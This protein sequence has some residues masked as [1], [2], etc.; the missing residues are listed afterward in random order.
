M[1]HNVNTQIE[2]VCGV[3]LPIG[4]TLHIWKNRITPVKAQRD[5]G[6][7][8]SIVTGI[9]GDELEGQY[10][11]Y[12]VIRRIKEHPECLTGTVDIYP[13]M[14]PL[15]IDSVTRG[16]PGFDL[17]MNRVFPG[18]E[19]GTMTEY[20]A[21]QIIQDLSGADLCVDIHASNI[22]L[23]EIP[24]IRINK[25]HKEKLLPLAEQMN[26]DFIWIHG[27]STVLEATLAYSLNSTGTPTLVVE[28]GV[29]MRITKQYC[30]Q[31]AD[32]LFH[33]MQMLGI[34]QS[35]T[36]PVRKPY[37]AETDESVIF[38]NAPRSGIFIPV[39]NH[40]Q[41]LEKGQMVGQI[42]DS[43]RGEVLAEVVTPESGILFTIREYPV[44]DEGSL[45]GRLLV[46]A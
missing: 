43:L 33:T 34:W 30:R 31:L 1:I 42:V 28:A 8:I 7:R 46:T 32:G 10:I 21:H 2:E 39:A 41:K 19:H 13:A 11:C 6:K 14:N 26:V 35:E 9:H 36:E 4:E 40:W 45:I 23:T 29:G 3:E 20:I 17:D 44:V 38:F 18:S 25:L 16:I 12:E 22:Y 37:I 24:Q 27:A 15:G 5:H